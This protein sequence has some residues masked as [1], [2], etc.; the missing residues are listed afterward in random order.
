MI[1]SRI[2]DKI[3]RYRAA[4]LIFCILLTLYFISKLNDLRLRANLSDFAPL[5]HPYM[6]VQQKLMD[7]FGGLHQVSIAVVVRQ[8]DIFN[9]DTLNKVVLITRQLYLL[10][11]VNP[12]RI[13]S[14][15]A[16]KIK[17]VTAYNE[18]FTVQR[19]MREAPT[20]AAGMQA[21]K[22]AIVRNPMLYGPVRIDS[23]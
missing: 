21:L 1:V 10:P 7:I 14:L 20:D 18:G 23:N 13:V 22:D 17:H 3:I 15:S 5:N 11:G 16:R 12:G 9:Y 2:A 8:G 4:L 6:K 19:L